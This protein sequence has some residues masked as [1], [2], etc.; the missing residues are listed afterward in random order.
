MI[1]C[2]IISSPFVFKAMV[3]VPIAD[4]SSLVQV[5]AWCH[6]LNQMLTKYHG[7]SGMRAQMLSSV[8]FVID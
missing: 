5:M 7:V 4:K 1:T 3:Q 2:S 8:I 6:H